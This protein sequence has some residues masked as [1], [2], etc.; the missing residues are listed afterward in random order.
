MG[1]LLPHWQNVQSTATSSTVLVPLAGTIFDSARSDEAISD[2]YAQYAP[3]R[4]TI[5]GAKA[6]P[7]TLVESLAMASVAPPCPDAKLA[8]LRLPGAVYP[9]GY[10]LRG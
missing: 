5:A 7:I 9:K 6:H 2:T 3:Q 10:Y 1:M 8:D 4:L